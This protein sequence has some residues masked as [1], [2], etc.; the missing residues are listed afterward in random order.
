MWLP[1]PIYERV[2]LFWLLLGL[3]FMSSGTYLG[4]EHSLTKAYFGTGI[5][6]CAWGAWIFIMRLRNRQAFKEAKKHRAPESEPPREEVRQPRHA[7]SLGAGFDPRNTVRLELQTSGRK[8]DEPSS[9]P[10]RKQ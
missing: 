8:P 7:S 5:I 10:T 4:F 3:L 6:C 2:P 9:A 1:T